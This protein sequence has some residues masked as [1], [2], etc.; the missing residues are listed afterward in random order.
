MVFR[1]RPSKACERCRNRRLRVSPNSA[2]RP[3]TSDLRLN[4]GR[5][6]TSVVK[7]VA[8]VLELLYHVPD[9]EIHSSSVFGTKANLLQGKL[10]KVHFN[11]SQNLYP[12]R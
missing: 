8:P 5:S 2:N 3:Q 6:A 10:W 12:Y 1:G 4:L 7:A 9:T 11:P